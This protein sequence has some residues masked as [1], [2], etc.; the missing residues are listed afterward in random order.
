MPK[1]I[2]CA[3]N[4]MCAMTTDLP[5]GVVPKA[6]V[7]KKVAVV[8]GGPAGIQAMQTLLDRGHDVTLYEKTGELGGHVIDAA[9]PS[10]K[11]DV[12]DYLTWMRHTA[13]QC[14]ARG[15]KILLNCAATP[16]RLAL[17]GY[18]ALI[19]ALGADPIVPK[20]PGIDGPNVA[21][22]PLWAWGPVPPRAPPRRCRKRRNGP[23]GRRASSGRPCP[24]PRAGPW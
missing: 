16:D 8:G 19:L 12:R 5:D 21:W 17:E 1:H 22:A 15:A 10:F 11:N 20:L 9:V 4:P 7:K 18:D 3:V 13:G 14:R 24:P 23:P 6:R 2:F